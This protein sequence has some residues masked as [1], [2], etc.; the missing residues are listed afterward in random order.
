MMDESIGLIDA[1]SPDAPDYLDG[2]PRR[3]KAEKARQEKR[4]Q[5]EEERENFFNDLINDILMPKGLVTEKEKEFI[6]IKSNASRSK[7]FWEC[8]LENYKEYQNLN[9]NKLLKS[10]IDREFKQNPAILLK[11]KMG[12]LPENIFD[13]NFYLE[14][15]A[16]FAADFQTE[17]K[18]SHFRIQKNESGANILVEESDSL[19]NKDAEEIVFQIW[20]LMNYLN[21]VAHAMF[22]YYRSVKN[23]M[24]GNSGKID[25]VNKIYANIFKNADKA[26][27]FER[28]RF[29]L[30]NRYSKI[31][32]A[33]KDNWEKRLDRKYD[34]FTNLNDAKIAIDNILDQRLDNINSVFT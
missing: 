21:E 5:E 23:E 29:E 32:L 16:R 31:I 26:E 3:W 27:D 8:W 15:I 18:A 11:G 24:S 25:D 9:G 17:W 22:D 12:T 13:I 2:N 7:C 30:L 10:Y 14:K 33:V 6:Y 34:G 4:R 28:K 20:D 19:R 1:S